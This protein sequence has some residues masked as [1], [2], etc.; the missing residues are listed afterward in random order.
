MGMGSGVNPALLNSFTLAGA[1][2]YQVVYGV[3]HAL[4]TPLMSVTNAISGST[5]LG[6]L[7]LLG[8]GGAGVTVL[9]SVATG[10]SAVNIV[11]GFL[12][13]QRMLDLFKRPGDQDHSALM[14]APGALLVVT[15]IAAPVLCSF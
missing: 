9:A 1:A 5:A 14:L 3:A 6:G 2:G 10:I 7:M 8:Q 4:H 11:G 13:T 12:V 15:P